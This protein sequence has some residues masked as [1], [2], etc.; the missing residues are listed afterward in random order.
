MLADK[1]SPAYTLASTVDAIVQM[2][3]VPGVDSPLCVDLAAL[4]RDGDH[5][6]ASSLVRLRCEE[7][8]FEGAV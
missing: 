2:L 3:A 5:V 8:R 7:E 4:L 1:W 6:G